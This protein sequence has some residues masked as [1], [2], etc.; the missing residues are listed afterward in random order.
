MI[1]IIMMMVMMM[2][3]HKN[4]LS[5]K[6]WNCC[7]VNRF[8]DPK[9]RPDCWGCL[10]RG[11]AATCCHWSTKDLVESSPLSSASFAS[12]AGSGTKFWPE[13]RWV[14]G[15]RRSRFA[16][17]VSGTCW[18]GTP[19]LI[20]STVSSKSWSGPC[21]WCRRRQGSDRRGPP[22]NHRNSNQI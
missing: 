13:F 19:S 15:H 10:T 6:V 20:R 2:I 1:I 8:S 22:R 17:L 7:L 9:I 3:R 16:G 18:S 21:C 11:V 12:F 14:V 4:W 5:I